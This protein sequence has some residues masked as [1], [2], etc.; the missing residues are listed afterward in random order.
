MKKLSVLVFSVL[1]CATFVFAL[2][3]CDKPEGGNTPD[4]GGAEEH[5]HSFTLEKAEDSFLKSSANCQHKAVYYKSCECGE[6]GTETFEAGELGGHNYFEM[7]VDEKY[8]ASAASCESPKSYYYSCVCGAVGTDTFGEGEP[9]GHIYDGYFCEECGYETS[10]EGLEFE[11]L[12][13]ADGW[14]VTGY[15]DDLPEDVHIA[16]YQGKRVYFIAA[17]A[18][19]N[20]TRIKTLYI[21]DGVSSF[22]SMGVGGKFY[23]CEN[24]ESVYFGKNFSGLD[25]A[26]G[27][28]KSLREIRVSEENEWLT[29][30]GNCVI[31]RK[32][33]AT[34]PGVVET[35]NALTLACSQS[36]IPTDMDIRFISPEAFSGRPV[37]EINI[38]DSVTHVGTRAFVNCTALREITIGRGVVSIE[39]TVFENCVSLETINYNAVLLYGVGGFCDGRSF[40]SVGVNT[41]GI[42]LNIGNAVER[43][44]ACFFANNLHEEPNVP[45]SLKLKSIVFEQGSALRSI[46]A[47]AFFGAPYLESLSLPD[48]VEIIDQRAFM[49]CT[50]LSSVDLGNAAVELRESC[51]DGCTSLSS[52]SLSANTLI[53]GANAFQNCVSLVELVIPDGIT[54]ISDSAFIRCEGLKRLVIPKSVEKI[55]AGAFACAYLLEEVYYNAERVTDYQYAGAFGGAGLDGDGIVFTVGA[56]VAVI[57]CGLLDG[58]SSIKIKALVFEEGGVCQSIG[59][60][61]FRFNTIEQPVIIP[62][63]VTTIGDMAFHC[64][65]TLFFEAEE[66]PSGFDECF[67][68]G[69]AEVYWYSE[70]N[71][72]GCW[73]YV[74]GVPTPW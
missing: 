69:A 70:E 66:A 68:G 74:G 37:T 29:L 15:N 62:S 7:V 1:I 20:C 10:S 38:P 19:D 61:A 71:V 44:P 54:S 57:P 58:Y 33:I 65:A 41:D 17:D 48:S 23:G 32:D 55:G 50:A 67:F 30:R 40:G 12:S 56:D 60:D 9:N 21:S 42:T 28:C 24:L 27:D 5:V 25:G 72:D 45:L 4:S 64:D 2:S 18:F 26:F 39:D 6:L 49:N 73:R 47:N 43:I 34:Q 31:E 3:S 51:F 11:A 53:K 8:F 63:S 16:N 59:E 35:V 22:L 52:L 36:V 13:N 14:I 46:G